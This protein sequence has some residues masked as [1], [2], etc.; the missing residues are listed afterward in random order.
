MHLK[1]FF[2]YTGHSSRIDYNNL[3]KI[4]TPSYHHEV[5]AY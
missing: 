4:S 2:R 1:G 5:R 3:S